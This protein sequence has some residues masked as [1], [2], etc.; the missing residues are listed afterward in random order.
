MNNREKR[1]RRRFLVETNEPSVNVSDIYEALRA[2]GILAN[3]TLLE[4]GD[5]V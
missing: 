2:R 1:F 5:N 3:V 4:Y